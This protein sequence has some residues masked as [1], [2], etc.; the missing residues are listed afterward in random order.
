M[1]ARADAYLAAR[2]S[3]LA[4]VRQVALVGDPVIKGGPG[5]QPKRDLRG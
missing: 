4:P 1:A 5:W 2:K 3:H